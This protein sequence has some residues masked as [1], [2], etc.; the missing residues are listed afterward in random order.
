MTLTTQQ[1]F[2]SEFHLKSLPCV[3]SR[4]LAF[5]LVALVFA[6]TDRV[7]ENMIIIFSCCVEGEVFGFAVTC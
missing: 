2:E 5:R 1:T 6:A 7:Q 4:Q 3:F